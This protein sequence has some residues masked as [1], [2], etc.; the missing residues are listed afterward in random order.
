[1][2]YSTIGF[3]GYDVNLNVHWM[4]NDELNDIVDYVGEIKN[5]K[6]GYDYWDRVAMVIAKAEE[7]GS[8]G[9]F[10]GEMLD[11]DLVLGEE[12][13]ILRYVCEGEILSGT[14]ENVSKEAKRIWEKDLTL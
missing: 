9:L 13:E 8:P 6:R 2:T 4:Q 1:M 3:Q 11:A 5:D 12:I 10:V 14:A 7:Y